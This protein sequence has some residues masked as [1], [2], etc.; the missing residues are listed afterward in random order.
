M[1]TLTAIIVDDEINSRDTLCYLLKTMCPTVVIAAQA[2]STSEARELIARLRPQLVFM[3]IQM[4][5]QSGIEFISSLAEMDFDVVFTTAY[6]EY[7]VKAFR[8]NAIDYL[9]KP[10]NPDELVAAVNKVAAKKNSFTPAQLGMLKQIWS[11]M[12]GALPATQKNNDRKLGVSTQDGLHFI[13]LKDIIWCESLGAYT[14]FHLVNGTHIVV[15]KL[16]KEYEDILSDYDFT[17]IHQS[18]IVNLRHVKKYSRTDGGMVEMSNGTQ[19]EVARRRKEDFQKILSSY[20]VN[21]GS[22]LA[23]R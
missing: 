14:R 3:D 20:A 12:Q 19:L 7:A 18:Y 8:L 6:D 1:E 15:S 23:G 4:P 11:D 5:G 13:E 10:I 22:N 2:Q 17:R 16:I 9:L 21:E